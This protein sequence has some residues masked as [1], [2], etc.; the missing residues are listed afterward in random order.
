MDIIAARA[1]EATTPPA[2]AIVPVRSPA[3]PPPGTPIPSHYALCFGCGSDHATGLRIRMAAVADLTVEA[4]F[5]VAEPH[6]GA[7]GLAHGGVLAA[8]VDE[9]MGASNWLLMAPAVTARLEVDFGAP[10]PVGRTVEVTAAIVG[11]S[12]RKVY[13]IADARVGDRPVMHARGLFLQVELQ[14]FRR[15]GRAADVDRAAAGGAP[16]R[17]WLELNP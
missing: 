17:P 13:T 1:S 15:H 6:Q 3:A 10:V 12:G 14:H 4:Q 9:V 2:D 5:T 7:P 16:D 8:A 11:Q